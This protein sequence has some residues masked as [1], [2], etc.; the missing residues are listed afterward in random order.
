VLARAPASARFGPE[1]LQPPRAFADA[2]I[3][4]PARIR[5][6]PRA[7]GP[8][9]SAVSAA[10]YPLRWAP[11]P[12]TVSL[13]ERIALLTLLAA[14]HV[15]TVQL[16]ASRLP[17]VIAR[18]AGHPWEMFLSYSAALTLLALSV[19]R[20]HPAWLAAVTWSARSAG[21]CWPPG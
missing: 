2:P 8:T 1:Q 14:A 7:W 6:A 21:Q 4:R 15:F 18:S 9:Q 16:S 17:G 13:G 19:F 5:R 3:A 12:A 11:A 20:P 10:A